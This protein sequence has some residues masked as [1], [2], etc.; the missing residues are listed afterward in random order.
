MVGYI[1]S[2]MSTF[3]YIRYPNPSTFTYERRLFRPFEYALQPPAWYKGEHIAVNKPELPY[4]MSSLK[5]YDGPQCFAI[6]GNHGWF[7][8]LFLLVH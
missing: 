5:E 2:W 7:L 8:F 1:L 3:F 6:P 4:G